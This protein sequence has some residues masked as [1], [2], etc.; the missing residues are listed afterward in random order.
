MQL[1]KEWEI[2][3][4]M[5]YSLIWFISNLHYSFW[6]IF[7]LLYIFSFMFY[8]Y[9]CLSVSLCLPLFLSV[10]LCLSLTLPLSVYLSISLSLSHTFFLFFSVV[11]AAV[12][13]ESWSGTGEMKCYGDMSISLFGKVS[14]KFTEIK[15]FTPQKITEQLV[16]NCWTLITK[17]MIYIINNRYQALLL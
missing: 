16:R 6:D 3:I 10:C 14:D 15:R 9:I 13:D 7:F 17:I 4:F 2:V 12:G 1:L 11:G 8:Q 5:N